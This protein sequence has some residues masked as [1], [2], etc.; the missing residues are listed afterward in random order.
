MNVPRS[1]WPPTVHGRWMD[2]G[3]VP[4]LVSV[5][6]PTYNRA[7]LLVETLDSV[8]RQ[9]Y[10]P[11]ELLVVDD[12]SRD[13]TP[14]RVAEWSARH[15]DDA[16]L[17]VV[18]HREPNRGAPAARNLGLILSRGEFLQFLDSDDLLHPDKIALQVAALREA[19]ELDLVCAMSVRFRDRPD[20]DAP[21]YSGMGFPSPLP[22]CLTDFTRFWTTDA[23]VYRRRTCLE[24][25]PWDEAL[26]TCQD[27]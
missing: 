21:P 26:V 2:G 15:A 17:E 8:R 13:D 14:Q 25:G 11:I 12:G 5:I 23:A 9:A 1:L 10:R 27:W 16:R 18:F 7:D 4:G 22:E 24:N 20:W 3:F 6:V 19:P